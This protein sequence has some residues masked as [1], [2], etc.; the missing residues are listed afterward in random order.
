MEIPE[1]LPDRIGK[2]KLTVSV[3][4]RK[5]LST[6]LLRILAR[7]NVEKY[8]ADVTRGCVVAR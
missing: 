2:R 1:K 3:V 8:V 6:P 4:G 7:G 5:D